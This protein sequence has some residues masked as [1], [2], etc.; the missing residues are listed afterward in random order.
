MI[1]VEVVEGRKWEAHGNT[2][3]QRVLGDE[4]SDSQLRRRTALISGRACQ[5]GFSQR[6]FQQSERLG[7]QCLSCDVHLSLLSP[8]SVK[9]Y[10]NWPVNL[11]EGG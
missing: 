3:S 7:L 5:H 11:E 8:V 4:H 2:N 6:G 10:R 9:R 1:G